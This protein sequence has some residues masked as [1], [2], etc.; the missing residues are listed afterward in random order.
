MS[1]LKTFE[2]E[3]KIKDLKIPPGIKVQG[4]P[5]RTVVSIVEAEKEITEITPT[6]EKPEEIKR[7]EKKEE[8]NK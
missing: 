8:E 2:D 1:L 7:V 4:Q 3:I 5:E 6:E